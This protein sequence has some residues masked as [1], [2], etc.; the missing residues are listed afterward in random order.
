MKLH[1]LALLALLPLSQSHAAGSESALLSGINA[2]RAQGISCAGVSR[3]RSAP[4]TWTATNSS[5]A[6]LQ[7]SYMAQ[8]GRVSH[9]GAGGTSPRVRAASTG[10]RG[11]NM[12]EIIYLNVGLN[13]S[14]AVN[15]WRNSPVHCY[16]LT[17]PA[18]TKAGMSIVRAGR[19]TAYVMVLS[20]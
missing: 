13:A 3:P 4:L 11:P 8:T 18:Y 16:A 5:A 17:N 15:W 1:L 20:N 12:S 9:T 2:L 7:A 19:G 14:Q 10:V 6:R